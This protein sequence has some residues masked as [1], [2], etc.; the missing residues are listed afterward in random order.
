MRR[1]EYV[2]KKDDCMMNKL[3]IIIPLFNEEE[4]IPYLYNRLIKVAE[5]LIIMI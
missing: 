5:K 2:N 3:S 1:R 4:A